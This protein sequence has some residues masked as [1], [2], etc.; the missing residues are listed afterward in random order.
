MSITLCWDIDAGQWDSELKKLEK[1]NLLQCIA[2]AKS[3]RLLHQQ[4][5]RLGVIEVGGQIAG[6]CLLLEAGVLM[7]AI[8][9]VI[10]D[11][12]PLWLNGY[13]TEEQQEAFFTEFNR[14]F[15]RRIGRKRRVIPEVLD[16]SEHRKI[17]ENSGFVRQSMP[18]YQ[19]L[20]LDITPD[21]D[22]LR[23]NLKKNWRGSLQKAERSAEDFIIEWDDRC[24][25]LR[26]FLEVYAMDKA[27]KGYHGASAKTLIAMA[28]TFGR[29]IGQCGDMVIGRVFYKDQP[30][31]VVLLLCH[32]RGATY[33]AGWNKPPKAYRNMGAHN[34]LLWDGIRILK[35]KG[36]THFDLGGI[37]EDRA[38]G[39]SAFKQGL[40][41]KKYGT[42]I[43]LCGLYS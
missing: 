41:G 26:W 1:T 30:M 39:V 11:R 16:N 6:L 19:T 28:K 43:T 3:Q 23:D 2:Y 37:N 15:P 32:G 5:F 35:E 7:N 21:L 25:L 14:Q 12:G 36:V 29:G 33:Q 18:G 31:A 20:Y 8:H 9:G 4:N 27:E 17:M 13:G 10:L 22:D 42:S 34:L 38:A 40:A 24:D